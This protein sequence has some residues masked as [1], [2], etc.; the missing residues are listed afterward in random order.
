MFK[1]EMFLARYEPCPKSEYML[2]TYVECHFKS[3]MKD[4][5]I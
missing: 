3:D 2:E 4:A 5:L 1:S